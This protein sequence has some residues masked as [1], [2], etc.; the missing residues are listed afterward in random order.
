M[1]FLDLFFFLSS[2][3]PLS[4][5][6][7]PLFSFSHYARTPFPSLDNSL[8]EKIFVTVAIFFAFFFLSLLSSFGGGGGKG[9]KV[10]KF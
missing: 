7:F 6:L 5:S 2:F 8:K 4:P 10:E 9:V 3:T 1:R